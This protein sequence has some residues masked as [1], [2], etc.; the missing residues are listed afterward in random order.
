MRQIIISD[1]ARKL[2]AGH[3][4][5]RSISISHQLADKSWEALVDDDMAYAMD[6]LTGDPDRAIGLVCAAHDGVWCPRCECYRDL[7]EH[8]EACSACKLVLP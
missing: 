3:I 8:G 2:L 1:R 7:D 5:S 4:L 6:C